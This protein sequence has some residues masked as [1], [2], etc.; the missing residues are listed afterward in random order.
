[1]PYRL[2]NSITTADI[3]AASASS[4]LH[5]LK[6]EVASKLAQLVV[7]QQLKGEILTRQK[8]GSFTVRVANFSVRMQLPEGVKEETQSRCV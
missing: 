3:E 7:G 4:G 2:D 8:D 6:Q 1:M 5:S